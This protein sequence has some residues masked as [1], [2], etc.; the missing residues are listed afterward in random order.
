MD[1][2][3]WNNILTVKGNIDNLV[4]VMEEV[5]FGKIPEQRQVFLMALIHCIYE[6]FQYLKISRE[7]AFFGM[8]TFWDN[9]EKENNETN[10]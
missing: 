8:N 4:D 7:N 5:G 2:D 1:D 9:V 6:E 10:T 3:F